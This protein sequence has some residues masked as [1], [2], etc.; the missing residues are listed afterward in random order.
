MSKFRKIVLMIIGLI[1]LVIVLFFQMPNILGLFIKDIPPIDDSDLKITKVDVPK[2]QNAYYILE[3][4]FNRDNAYQS[5]PSDVNPYLTGEKEWDEEVV[6]GILSQYSKEIELIYNAADMPKFQDPYANDGVSDGNDILNPA[7]FMSFIRL[8]ALDS[9]YSMR[10]GKQE[11]S[12]DKALKLLSLG[13]KIENSQTTFI[14]YYIGSGIKATGLKTIQSLLDIVKAAPGTSNMLLH[15]QNLLS[16]YI[17]DSKLVETPFKTEY[18]GWA[19]QID[20]F[21]LGDFTQLHGE[22]RELINK[23]SDKFQFQPNRTKLSAANN[24][25]LFISDFRKS[26]NLINEI[27]DRRAKFELE[28]YEIFK[29]STIIKLYFVKN[30]VGEIINKYVVEDS[31]TFSW[32]HIFEARCNNEV[33]FS[34]TRLLMLLKAYAVEEGK[35]PDSL[36][37]V[38]SKY[39]VSIPI[40]PYS[41]SSMKYNKGKKIIYSIGKDLKDSGGSEGDYWN[42]MDDPTFNIGF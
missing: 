42:L 22:E 38:I 4:L 5:P 32:N 18:T 27:K 20:A 6:K 31:Y 28:G 35:L 1:I 30:T 41:T 11:E 33:L 34:S 23:L 16:Q 26:C 21:A 14:L 10:N 7:L 15:Y 29:K 37:D 24:F 36:E 40:D 39:T 9:V 2:E 8:I 25:R 12:F 3:P 17:E 19:N 13:Q